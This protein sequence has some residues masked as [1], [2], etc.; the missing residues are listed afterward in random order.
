MRRRLYFLLVILVVPTMGLAG[1]IQTDGKLKSTLASGAP[2]EVTSS[3]MVVNLNADMVDGVQGTDIYTKA[4][5]DALVAAALNSVTPTQYYMSTAR[6]DGSEAWDTCAAGFHMAS[7][8]E[9]ADPSNLRYAHDHSGASYNVDVGKG[10]PSFIWAWIRTGMSSEPFPDPGFAQC[11]LWTSNS[12]SNWGTAATLSGNWADPTAGG[13]IVVSG[14]P[15]I[16]RVFP[17][18]HTLKVWCVED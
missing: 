1:D 18:D 4:E 17:C 11:Q 7:L 5:V 6:V 2:L 16:A 14:T 12:D 3:S 9:I 8:W 10:P 15:W 13:F